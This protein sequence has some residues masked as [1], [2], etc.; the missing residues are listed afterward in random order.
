MGY[1]CAIIGCSKRYGRDKLYRFYRLP[2]VVTREGKEHEELTRKRQ[3][4]WLE[5]ISRSDIKT[6]SYNNIRVC[7]DHFVSGQPSYLYDQTNPDWAPT[8]NL[9]HMKISEASVKKSI[10]RN[11]RLNKRRS[12]IIKRR[13][14]DSR[15]PVSDDDAGAANETL[16][17]VDEE[18]PRVEAELNGDECF[19]PVNEDC[20]TDLSSK[21]IA[22]LEK[23][24]ENANDEIYRLRNQIVD[25]SFNMDSFRNDDAKVRYFTGLPNFQVLLTVYNFVAPSITTTQR[26]S[27][28][29]FQELLIVLIRLRLNSSFQDLGY[30]FSVSVSTISRIFYRWLPVLDERLSFLICWPEREQLQKTMPVAF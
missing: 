16:T 12:N 19:G 27:L 25:L 22:S 20:Q 6:S 11:Q 15:L 8:R 18:I 13:N 24:L 26:N 4:K 17:A 14:N 5:N 21:D 10:E 2:S 29:K 30:R 28:T 3:R 7:S 9:G 1:S 23:C